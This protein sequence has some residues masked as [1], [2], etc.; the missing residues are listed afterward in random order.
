MHTRSNAK[1]ADNQ[2][3]FTTITPAKTIEAVWQDFDPTLVIDPTSE[4][5]IPR[6]DPELQKLSFN[7]KQGLIITSAT[8]CRSFQKRKLDKEYPKT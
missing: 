8:L 1:M 5:Y 7:L 4:Q 6:T 3:N 2:S